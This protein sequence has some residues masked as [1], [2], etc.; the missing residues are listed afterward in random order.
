MLDFSSFKTPLSDDQYTLTRLNSIIDSMPSS[1]TLIHVQPTSAVLLG[2]SA[3]FVVSSGSFHANGAGLS[4]LFQS[5]LFA[6]ASLT[7][8]RMSAQNDLSEICKLALAKL[9]RL[10][11]RVGVSPYCC[12]FS[13]YS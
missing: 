12:E 11:S 1:D 5:S 6:S 4:S 13:I 2:S 7:A 8:L 3:P 9:P 10:W